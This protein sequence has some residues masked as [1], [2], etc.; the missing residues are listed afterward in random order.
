MKLEKIKLKK[1][2]KK[3]VGRGIS[4]GQGKTAGR[5]TKGQKSRSGYKKKRGFEGGQNPLTQRLPKKKGFKSLNN[6]KYIV[7]NISIFNKFKDGESVDALKLKKEG[8]I[9]SYNGPIKVLGS[10][11]L[12][13]KVTVEAN[14]FSKKAKEIIKKAGGEVI[15]I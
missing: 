13:K 14:A 8:L 3:R 2:S 9:S 5:G 12:K 6:I 10:G 11:E 15:E 4:G 7:V 1:K